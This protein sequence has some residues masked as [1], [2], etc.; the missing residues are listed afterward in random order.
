M[1][2]VDNVQAATGAHS[3]DILLWT[4]PQYDAN[5]AVFRKAAKIL[6]IHSSP[7][8]SLSCTGGYFVSGA[9]DGYIRFFDGRLRLAAWFEVGL[10]LVNRPPG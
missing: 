1:S 8:H 7:V 4:P 10:M 5:G 2:G 3:G 6:S 9:A